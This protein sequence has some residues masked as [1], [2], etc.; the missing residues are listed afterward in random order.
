MSNWFDGRAP[1]KR[2][3]ETAHD[4]FYSLQQQHTVSIDTHEGQAKF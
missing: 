4:K 3:I 2:D 1:I